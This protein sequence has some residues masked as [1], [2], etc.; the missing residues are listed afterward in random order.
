MKRS[1]PFSLTI[2]T[3]FGLGNVAGHAINLL[4]SHT[5]PLT[6]QIGTCAWRPPTPSAAILVA[7]WFYGIPQ[8]TAWSDYEVAMANEFLAAGKTAKAADAAVKALED[9]FSSYI[10]EKSP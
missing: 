4:R 8:G 3:A 2:L 5:T 6:V 9:C 10:P 1:L 7:G